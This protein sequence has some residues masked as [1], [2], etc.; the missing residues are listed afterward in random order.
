MHKAGISD[1]AVVGET[2]SG[3]PGKILIT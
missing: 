2:V 1:A 3:Y